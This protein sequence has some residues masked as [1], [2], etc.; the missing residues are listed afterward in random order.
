M[1]SEGAAIVGAAGRSPSGL[2]LVAD[3]VRG[4]GMM[5]A[6]T[7]IQQHLSLLK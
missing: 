2:A 4:I 5:A 7:Y 6:A 1:T 3:S